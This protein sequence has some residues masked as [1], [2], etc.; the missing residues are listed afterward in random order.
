V[1]FV[2]HN[3]RAAN[4]ICRTGMVLDAGVCVFQG[5]AREAT[6]H[7]FRAIHHAEEWLKEASL[8]DLETAPRLEGS[9]Q[10]V[11]AWVSMHEA[12][13]TPAARF[14]TGAGIRFR[15][16][17]RGARAP[18]PYFSVLLVNEFGDRVAT[19]H[20]TQTGA[21]LDVSG[22]GVLE[23]EVPALLLGEGSYRVM[24]D[25]GSFGGSRA[26][27]MSLDCVPNAATL[28]VELHGY[29]QGI[30]LDA[31]QGAAH[32]STWRRVAASA[33]A[34]ERDAARRCAS[35]TGGRK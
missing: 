15:I 35:G 26:A 29:L 31:Y 3:A 25:H 19:I 1:L 30:G 28:R 4:A 21:P 32:R 8:H 34:P 9:T 20:S 14:A 10:R 6:T 22:D 27:M 18:D 12:D 13:G 5:T 17:F 24:I 16:G 7:Y 23:C 33:D 2:S 11:L